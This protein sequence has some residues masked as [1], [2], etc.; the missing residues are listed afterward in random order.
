MKISAL[1]V[2][3]LLMIQERVVFAEETTFIEPVA[4]DKYAYEVAV[5]PQVQT[6]T[7]K[8]L[9]K[10]TT[11]S[12][13]AQ[14]DN[15]KVLVNNY[16]VP[17]LTGTIKY[18]NDIMKTLKEDFKEISIG[19]ERKYELK[20]GVQQAWDNIKVLVEPV[21]RE[22]NLH[23]VL[24]P[25]LIEKMV[26]DYKITIDEAKVFIEA[27]RSLS[28]T[29]SNTMK[30]M[31]DDNQFVIK[32]AIK[33]SETKYIE[34]SKLK[35][36]LENKLKTLEESKTTDDSKLNEKIIDLTAQISVEKNI[37]IN[38]KA[39][40]STLQKEYDNQIEEI[41]TLKLKAGT[42]EKRIKELENQKQAITNQHDK[43]LATLADKVNEINQ[44]KSDLDN[45]RKDTEIKTLTA[46]LQECKELKDASS[47][48][49]TNALDATGL[50]LP[51]VFVVAFLLLLGMWAC[52]RGKQQV[53]TIIIDGIN[54]AITKKPIHP[55]QFYNPK[56]DYNDVEDSIRKRLN[57][58]I[59]EDFKV[60]IE[61]YENDY[62]DYNPPAKGTKKD[63]I[64]YHI[65]WYRKQHES[66]H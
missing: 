40:Y 57:A 62:I 16:V 24:M 12:E 48:F 6:E 23:D 30:R 26:G 11:L 47:Q 20:I 8:Y 41:E 15:L 64:E 44:L 33:E 34:L 18:Y 32:V 51:G 36:E 21:L 43:D 9:E 10:F 7:E 66:L 58:M 39:S 50:I 55:H 28:S 31:T 4:V 61:R 29:I 52:F 35:D 27:I 42:D 5:N 22:L 46:Q 1:F 17:E 49:V 14:V 63:K 60:W 19:E 65:E 37:N 53:N 45:S 59:E 38:L 3:L 2:G 13:T 25:I 54:Y 56:V